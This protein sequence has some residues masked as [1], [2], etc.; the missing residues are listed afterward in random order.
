MFKKRIKQKLVLSLVIT[1]SL[2]MAAF[3]MILDRY[4]K[5]HSTSESEQTVVLLG[6]NAST[7]LQRP[8]FYADY[9]Q[10]STIVQPIILDDFDYLVIFDNG[11]RNVAFKM[12]EKGITEEMRWEN[13]PDIKPD[14]K[15]VRSELALGGGNYI[16][17]IFPVTEPTVDKPL[18]F[19]IIGISEKSMKSKLTGITNRILVISVLL[20]VSLTATIYLLADKVV[21]PIKK[22][23]YNIGKFASGDYSVRSDIKSKDE[24]GNLSYNFNF[25]ADKI[26]EQIEKIERHSKDLEKN[27][28]ERTVELLK[29][30]DAIKERDKKLTQAEKISSLNAIVSSIAH[31][32]NNPLAIISGNLQLM[33]AKVEEEPLRKKLGT[34]QD[35]IDRIA[36]LIDEINFFAA[37][38]DVS[39][40]PLSFSGVLTEVVKRIVPE[41][42]SLVIRGEVQGQEGDVLDTNAHLLTVCLENVI[43]NSVDI[44]EHKEVNGKLNIRYYKDNPFFILEVTDNGGGVAEP[45]K[46]FDPF[47]TTFNEKKGLGL[48]FVYHAIQALNGEVY[49]ENIEQS[50]GVE[51]GAKV[52]LMFPLDVEPGKPGESYQWQP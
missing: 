50:G 52:I 8:L 20:F 36:N 49:V 6:N 38:K 24:I 10:L 7:L 17:Y 1:I 42:V 3:F 44:F 27:V 9:N 23:S 39:T 37:I 12:D 32:I 4:L 40:R 28:E 31:E 14:E 22:L 2:L 18:G 34:A 21:K 13:M 33:D 25:L 5:D 15:F 41:G 16:Q 19:L 46:V 45:E 47:Y 43:Q 48:T 51:K 11:T 35:A 29:A 26:N 30:L